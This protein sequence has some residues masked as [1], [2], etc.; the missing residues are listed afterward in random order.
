MDPRTIIYEKVFFSLGGKK[1]KGPVAI[2]RILYFTHHY[3]AIEQYETFSTPKND[4][5]SALYTVLRRGVISEAPS[6]VHFMPIFIG[7]HI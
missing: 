4:S 5:V 7:T 3:S 6:G 1:V 2:N